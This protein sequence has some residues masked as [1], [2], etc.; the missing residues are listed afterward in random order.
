MNAS[1]RGLFL[2]K[3]VKATLNSLLYGQTKH[4]ILYGKGT[5]QEKQRR[6]LLHELLVQALREGFP[7]MFAR[8]RDLEQDPVLLQRKGAR[9]FFDAYHAGLESTGIAAGIPLHDGW[10][11]G[12]TEGQAQQ[13]QTLWQDIGVAALQIPIQAKLKQIPEPRFA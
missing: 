5:Q 11:F 13:I 7:K 4:H 2:E 8:L 9:I 6:A 10:I 1:G 3:E 12:A